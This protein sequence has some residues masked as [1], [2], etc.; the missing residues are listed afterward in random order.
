MK[1]FKL[2]KLADSAPDGSF[3]LGS[4]ELDSSSVYMLYSKLRHGEAPKKLSAPEGAEE[5][6]FVIKGNIRVRCGKTDFIIGPGE[7]FHSRE[8][9]A[10]HL[11]NIGS[12]DAVFIAAGGRGAVKDAKPAEK[13]SE[14]APEVKE[15]EAAEEEEEFFI[16]REDEP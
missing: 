11:E 2:P 3:C 7:A 12:E 14:E 13:P 6:I 4:P 8:C 15:A 16:T 5:I 1:I 9:A 10:F